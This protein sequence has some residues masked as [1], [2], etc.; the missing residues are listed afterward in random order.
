MLGVS[1]HLNLP[2]T[3]LQWGRV[4]AAGSEDAGGNGGVAVEPTE[5]QDAV[6][7]RLPRR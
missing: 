1:C 2:P 5:G 3:R 4:T 7:W 6:R